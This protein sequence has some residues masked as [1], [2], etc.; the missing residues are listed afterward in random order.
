MTVL[1]GSKLIWALVKFEG[2]AVAVVDVVKPR[3]KFV[4][5]AMIKDP[6]AFPVILNVEQA[7]VP[8]DI[9]RLFATVI[10]LPRV[11][12][13]LLIVKLLNVVNIVV[14]SVFVVVN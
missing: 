14:G 5:A 13:P 6:V 2:K 3:V 12:V 9:V 11:V 8:P 4:D 1:V 10:A 7:N